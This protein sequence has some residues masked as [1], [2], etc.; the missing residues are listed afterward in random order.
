MIMRSDGGGIEVLAGDRAYALS[1]RELRGLLFLR[2]RVDLNED[3]SDR[4]TVG[5]WSDRR[6]VRFLL[7]GRPYLISSDRVIAVLRGDVPA[8]ELV[9]VG[10]P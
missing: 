6:W 5:P 3:G 2:I 8:D 10:G 7:G 4:A 9:R 1:K